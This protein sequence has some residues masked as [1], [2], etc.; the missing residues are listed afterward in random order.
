M[1]LVVVGVQFGC[2]S[3]SVCECFLQLVLLFSKAFMERR[4][5]IYSQ[6]A[7]SF[8]LFFNFFLTYIKAMLLIPVAA[9]TAYWVEA[10]AVSKVVTPKSA[11]CL[12]AP[13]TAYVRL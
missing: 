2:G 1:K 6:C 4:E 13:S 3:Y 8:F 12:K 5:S 10:A 7:S 9:A 11:R